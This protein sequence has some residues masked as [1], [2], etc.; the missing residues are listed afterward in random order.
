M[1]SFSA[2]LAH[3]G[4]ITTHHWSACQVQSGMSGSPVTSLPSRW[5]QP[6]VW[7][8]SALSA[9]S[10]HSD[11][12][13]ATNIHQLRRHYSCWTSLVELS[14]SPAAQSTHHRRTAQMTADGTPWTMNTALCHFWCVLC[15]W[16]C[17]APMTY[18]CNRCTINPRMIMMRCPR[19]TLTYLLNMN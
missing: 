14:S 12:R 1:G 13:R 11:L 3:T 17:N 5:L 2:C 6:C 16:L 19:K 18:H 9:V 7:Q 8:H 10:R 4:L 15:G